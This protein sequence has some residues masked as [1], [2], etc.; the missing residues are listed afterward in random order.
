LP[1]HY[2]INTLRAKVAE[3]TKAFALQL[4]Q[5]GVSL[6]QTGGWICGRPARLCR[7]A[8]FEVAAKD[9]GLLWLRAG[10]PKQAAWKF[11]KSLRFCQVG[12][13]GARENDRLFMGCWLAGREMGPSIFRKKVGFC[14]VELLELMKTTVFFG[15]VGPSA[16]ILG[17]VFLEKSMV[18]SGRQRQMHQKWAKQEWRAAF[19]LKKVWFCQVGRRQ[20]GIRAA[21]FAKKVRFC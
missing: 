7:I 3:A 11:R 1:R 18:F 21:F 12:Q 20:P 10:R 9:C 19:F 17:R 6:K 14:Q 15:G 16:G 5:Q 4:P 2:Y 8:R 13:I